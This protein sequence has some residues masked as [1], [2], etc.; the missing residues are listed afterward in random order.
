MGSRVLEN[1]AREK[2]N[3]HAGILFGSGST[4]TQSSFTPKIGLRIGCCVITT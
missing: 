3:N 2:K 1:E 4:D